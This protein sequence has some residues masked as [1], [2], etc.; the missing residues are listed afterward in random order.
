[1]AGFLP[2][3]LK[4]VITAIDGTP[5]GS[6]AKDS[7]CYRVCLVENYLMPQECLEIYP[8]G[9][10][11]VIVSSGV[12]EGEFG[13]W[14][15]LCP[16]GVVTSSFNPMVISVTNV[17]DVDVIY[18]VE[19]GCGEEGC[20]STVSCLIC[21]KLE[22]TKG[23]KDFSFSTRRIESGSRLAVRVSDDNG[24]SND[25]KVFVSLLKHPEFLS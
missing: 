15:E 13:D 10:T 7:L 5:I 9:V 19:I 20:E 4:E 2:N 8:T 14:V 25:I 12:V 18:K 23:V 6:P 3:V 22:A 17:Q 1:M 21:G 16:S 24:S 11:P